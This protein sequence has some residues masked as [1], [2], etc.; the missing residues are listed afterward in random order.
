MLS[1]QSLELSEIDRSS[2]RRRFTSA[3]EGISSEPIKHV[4][5]SSS[6]LCSLYGHS[7]CNP[8]LPLDVLQLT[9]FQ[10]P[11]SLSQSYSLFYAIEILSDISDIGRWL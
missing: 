4:F 5:K 10:K 9:W 1:V 6:S 7:P 8:Q 2:T 3:L 11:S